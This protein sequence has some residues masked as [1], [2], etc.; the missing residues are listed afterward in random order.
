MFLSKIIGTQIVD[1]KGMPVG[2]LGDLVAVPGDRFPAIEAIIARGRGDDKRISWGQVESC[3]GRIRLAV[4]EAE[5][6]ADEP[7]AGEFLVRQGILDK[8]I[9]D[10]HDY[11]VVRVNDVHVTVIEDRLRLIGVDAGT[12]GLLRRMG[13]ERLGELLGKVFRF[14][15][16]TRLISWADVEALDTETDRVKLKVPIDRIRRLHPAEIASIVEGLDPRERAQV[17]EQLDIETAG[18]ALGDA[19]AEVAADVIADL[20]EEH[21]ADILE[22]MEPDEAADILG[23]LPEDKREDLLEKM[24]PEE[25]EEV[26]ELLQFEDNTAGGLMTTEVISISA[27]LTVQQTIDKLRELKPDDH[28]IYYLYIVDSEEHLVGV[29]SLRQLIIADPDTPISE[30]MSEEVERCGL[31]DSP[32]EIAK[33]IARYDLLAVPVVDDD[34]KLLGIVTVDDVM[35][36]IIPEEIGKPKHRRRE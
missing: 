23:D 10:V 22:E 17:M 16:H 26:E 21:A 29:L 13:L 1:S 8:Q 2:R 4:P 34:N 31:H 36:Y 24:E 28:L 19:D 15:L 12:R 6:V 32:E 14:T 18:D 30:I 35:D 11:R 20:R 25:R 5:I 27:E 3:D 33:T 9:V 7:R